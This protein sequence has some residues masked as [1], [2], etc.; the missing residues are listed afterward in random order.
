MVDL[1]IKT[2]VGAVLIL[3]IQLVSRTNNYYIAG[4]VPLFPSLALISHYTVGTQRSVADLK[5]TILFGMCSLIPYFVYLLVLYFLVD[6]FK[7]VVSL[8]GAVGCWVAAAVVL[9]ALWNR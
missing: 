7:L 2:L 5:E 4:L 9:V 1:L 6:R 3:I 8:L